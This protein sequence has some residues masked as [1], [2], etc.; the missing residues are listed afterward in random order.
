M[1]HILVTGCNGLIGNKVT[2]TLLKH[3][4]KVIGLSTGKSQI[5]GHQHFKY[6]SGDLTNY[7]VV[8]KIFKDYKINTVIHL[9]AIAHLKGRGNIDWNM[10]YRVNTLA[11]KN[12]FEIAS[13]NKVKV[14][15]ASTVD[16]YGDRTKSVM[17]KENMI[18]KP[19]SNYAK[20]KYLG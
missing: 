15:Y 17:L 4:Y 13:Q 9:A 1:G 16:V 2:E 19:I 20:S 11:S 5:Q 3:H 14:F 12:L 6:I 7:M 18:P 8:K 10:Y